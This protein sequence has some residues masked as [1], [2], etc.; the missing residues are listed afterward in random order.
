MRMGAKD[1]LI[2]RTALPLLNQAVMRKYGE[3]TKLKLDT[4]QRSIEAEVELKGE[5]QPIQVRV[6]EYE[7]LQEGG[8]AY[9]VLK[10]ISTSREWLTALARDFAVGRKF[11]VPERVRGYLSMLG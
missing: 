4:A 6:H 8:T 10:D 7:I 9:V 2:E 1:W 5:T 11:E 3:M